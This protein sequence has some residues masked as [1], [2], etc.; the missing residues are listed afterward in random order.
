MKNF[1]P[2]G[3]VEESYS[4]FLPSYN[5]RFKKC[6]GYGRRGCLEMKNIS[7]TKQKTNSTNFKIKL[8]KTSLNHNFMQ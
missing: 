8:C 4:F 7:F 5:A 3:E 2:E 1:K 6:C